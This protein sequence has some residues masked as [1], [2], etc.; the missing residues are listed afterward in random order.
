MSVK[1]P[2]GKLIPTRMDTEK[3]KSEA[4]HDNGWLVVHVDDSKLNWM[5]QQVVKN[6]G[7]KLY[8]KPRNRG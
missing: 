5:E 3:I 8:G 7:E 1:S 2:L 4:W 6:I